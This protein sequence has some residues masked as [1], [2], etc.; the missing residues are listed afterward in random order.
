MKTNIKKLKI[1]K[2]NG[3]KAYWW[4]GFETK[5]ESVCLIEIEPGKSLD[6]MHLL[7]EEIETE[8]ILDGEATYEGDI[9]GTFRPGDVIEQKGK[10]KLIK[11][12]N[13]GN[14]PLR[15]LCVNRPPWRQ[16]H[17]KNFN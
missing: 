6:H 17:E 15:I 9:H 3:W 14:K 13:T 11:I 10:S 2:H 4:D 16:E 12:K 1:D 8:I 5:E 7:A